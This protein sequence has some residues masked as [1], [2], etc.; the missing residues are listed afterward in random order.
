MYTKIRKEE[1]VSTQE[2]EGRDLPVVTISVSMFWD[3]DFPLHRN[4]R[5]MTK[6][7]F[8]TGNAL[9]SPLLKRRRDSRRK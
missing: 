8:L 3:L 4:E 5:D 2:G 7:V 6:L 1:C 9:A